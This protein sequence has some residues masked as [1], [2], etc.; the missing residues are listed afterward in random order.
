MNMAKDREFI[1]G[2]RRKKLDRVDETFP[3]FGVFLLQ[4]V[5]TQ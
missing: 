4:I 5:V 1:S 2:L 3:S